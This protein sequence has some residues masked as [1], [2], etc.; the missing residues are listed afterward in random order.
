MSEYKIIKAVDRWNATSDRTIDDQD[1]VTLEI[2]NG[3]KTTTRTMTVAEFRNSNDLDG[4]SDERTKALEGADWYSLKDGAALKE[5]S[6]KDRINTSTSSLPIVNSST[7]FTDAILAK[8]REIVT[9]AVEFVEG[10][11]TVV[12]NEAD[13]AMTM[14]LWM[15]IRKSTATRTW[16]AMRSSAILMLMRTAKS[17]RMLPSTKMRKIAKWM[18]TRKRMTA[19]SKE[20]KIRLYPP[21]AI[22]RSLRSSLGSPAHDDFRNS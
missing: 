21:M 1:Q 5:F 7:R 8:G 6:L 14:S 12:V 20:R 15:T 18:T 3:D 19:S 16:M 10:I 9:A 13:K 22:P 2:K 17:T 4:T 11:A